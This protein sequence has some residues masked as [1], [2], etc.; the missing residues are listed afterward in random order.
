MSGV[1]QGQLSDTAWRLVQEVPVLGRFVAVYRDL[2]EIWRRG[3]H[4]AAG[5]RD[6]AI[7]RAATL[8]E[9]SR[10]GVEL[11]LSQVGGQLEA[12]LAKLTDLTKRGVADA[13]VGQAFYLTLLNE[14]IIGRQDLPLADFVVRHLN[15]VD[16]QLL[17]MAYDEPQQWQHFEVARFNWDKDRLP[18]LTM[19]E[20]AYRL[21]RL[22]DFGFFRSQEGTSAASV[23]QR[24]YEPDGAIRDF[25]PKAG[26]VR[27]ITVSPGEPGAADDIRT[28]DDPDPIPLSWRNGVFS[29]EGGMVRRH[30]LDGYQ[31][32]VCIENIAWKMRIENIALDRTVKRGETEWT[33][34]FATAADAQAAATAELERLGWWADWIPLGA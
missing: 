24:S 30:I 20:V 34:T 11:R 26:I 3:P 27:G 28:S 32:K 5:I 9:M 6:E 22:Q 29:D 7:E 2:D 17:L 19:F 21:A 15:T 1:T 33:G 4:R 13:A 31:W 25:I 14:G 8:I 10:E 12:A 16:L 18:A 23:E